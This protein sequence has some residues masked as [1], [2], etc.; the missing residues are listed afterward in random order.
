MRLFRFTT[1]LALFVFTGIAVFA[2]DA[3]RFGRSGRL[4]DL[5][6]ELVQQSERLGDAAYDEY[7]RKNFNNRNDAESLTLAAQFDATAAVFRRMVQDRRRNQE[8]RDVAQILSGLVKQS[9]RYG[10]QRSEW[11]EVRRTVNDIL[12][13]LNT[14][15]GGGGGNTGGTNTGS[16]RWRG[17]VDDRVQLVIQGSYLEE[18]AV[19]GTPYNN[20]NYNFNGALPNRQVNVRVNKISGRGDVRVIQQPSRFN[21]FTAI[22]EIRDS[23]GGARDYEVEIYW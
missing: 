3:E 15:G 14:G 16:I 4:A 12:S 18:R 10:S 8:L 20:G 2:Q 17:T 22:I 21:D 7:S 11:N 1:L 13:E 23:S 6:N 9:D 19:S 5:A